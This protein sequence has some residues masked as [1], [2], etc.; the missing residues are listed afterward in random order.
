MIGNAGAHSVNAALYKKPEYDPVADFAPI[1]EVAAIPLALVVHPSVPA[2]SVQALIA[3]TRRNNGP[4]WCV[5]KSTKRAKSCRLRVCR[6]SD[7]APSE[8]DQ[9]KSRR[10]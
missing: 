4:R 9:P 10:I 6:N 8:A 7:A 2:K 1:T 3:P 5:R